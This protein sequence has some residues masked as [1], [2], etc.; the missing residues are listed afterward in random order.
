M[1]L[2]AVVRKKRGA[3][4]LWPCWLKDTKGIRIQPNCRYCSTFLL[5][6]IFHLPCPFGACTPAAFQT[7]CPNHPRGSAAP[8]HDPNGR[9]G[10]R[11]CPPKWWNEDVPRASPH[12]RWEGPRE[13][14][15]HQ[16][17][18]DWPS[19]C[20]NYILYKEFLCKRTHTYTYIYTCICLCVYMY[21]C[22]M[23]VCMYVCMYACMHACMYVCMYVRMY[24]C[25]YV[26]MHGCMYV[27]MDG[28]IDALMYVCMH[29]YI[30]IYIVL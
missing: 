1:V 8:H 21:V 10:W 7:E 15:S 18:T 25:T 24:V 9:R 16:H 19:K 27:W 29:A 4:C 17:P 3:W 26:C 22:C 23:Y 30:Y 11:R 13:L 14:T 6:L 28:C 20:E 5:F 12:E 2:N